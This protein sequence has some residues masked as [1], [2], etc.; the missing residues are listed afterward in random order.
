MDQ[1]IFSTIFQEQNGQRTKRKETKNVREIRNHMHKNIVWLGLFRIF[2]WA[3]FVSSIDFEGKLYTFIFT[4]YTPTHTQPIK[5][6][7]ILPL[8][9]KFFKLTIFQQFG[10]FDFVHPQ[11][12]KAG[13]QIFN[14]QSI[15]IMNVYCFAQIRWPIQQ[16]KLTI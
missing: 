3:K 15:F 11:T 12:H 1:V 8:S 2:L 5:N 16:H 14:D 10:Q 4:Y 6:L 7:K 9:S 13:I